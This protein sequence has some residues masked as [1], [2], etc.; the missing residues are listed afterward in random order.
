MATLAGQRAQFTWALNQYNKTDDVDEQARLAKRM[1]KYIAAAP[2]NRFTAEQVTQGQSYPAAEV[3][4]YLNSG[5][6][7]VE[8]AEI[9]EQK[10]LQL[11]ESTVDTS[12]VIRDGQGGGTLYVY[13]YRCAPDRV[14]VG[15]TEPNT[16]AGS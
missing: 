13:G 6:G 10:A 14:K 1:A 5:I 15:I 16:N 12:D 2:N 7:D 4:N 9:S 8:D 3:A 11:L